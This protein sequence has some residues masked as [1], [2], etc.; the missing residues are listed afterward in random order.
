LSPSSIEDE[1]EN[2]ERKKMMYSCV[3]FDTSTTSTEDQ[4]RATTFYQNTDSLYNQTNESTTHAQTTTVNTT[5]VG[6]IGDDLFEDDSSDDIDSS[7]AG[8]Y[9]AEIFDESVKEVLQVQHPNSQQSSPLNNSSTSM[10]SDDSIGNF[11]ERFQRAI[12]LFTDLITSNIGKNFF[13]FV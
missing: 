5:S 4:K 2:L 12:S 13:D 3:L 10:L 8:A 11:N 9:P 6:Y 1:T 7:T